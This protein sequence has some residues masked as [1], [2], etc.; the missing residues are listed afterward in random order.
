MWPMKNIWL[1][2]KLLKPLLKQLNNAEFKSI[3]QKIVLPR[4]ELQLSWEMINAQCT[5]QLLGKEKRILLDLEKWSLVEESSLT[6]K[7]CAKWIKFGD[8]NT[9][10]FLALVKER[11]QKKQKL[12]P[13]SLTGAQLTDPLDIKEENIS[14]Y[15][16]LMGTTSPSIPA[17]NRLIMMKGP[18]LS[19]QQ[20][21]ELCDDITDQDKA[22]DSVEQPYLKQVISELGFPDSFI[23]WIMECVR[24]VNYTVMVNG[25]TTK[26]FDAAKGLRQGDPISPYLFSM[27]MEYLSRKLHELRDDKSFNFHPKCAKLKI[28]HLSF[29]DDLLL[30]SRG[31]LKSVN[32][33]HQAFKQFLE[34]SGLQ[35]YLHKSS[36]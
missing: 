7:A 18:T 27:A 20:R 21:R 28:A 10:Y 26:P 12:H 31:D 17:V 24:I 6:Q 34:A 30:F 22:Y 3:S 5:D 1:K 29:A 13:T 15:K 2:L 4:E 25:E 35:A 9:K 16:S 19:Q 8:A 36:I 11:T 33:L 32:A 14:F 23:S